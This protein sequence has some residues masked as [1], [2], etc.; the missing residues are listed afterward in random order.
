[1]LEN[2]DKDTFH[3]VPYNIRTVNAKNYSWVSLFTSRPEVTA[4]NSLHGKRHFW[5]L[6]IASVRYIIRYS[7]VSE[8]L[9]E[10]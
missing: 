5:C 9:K 7:F 3:A 1:M 2:T 4:G 10:I 8:S 6:I